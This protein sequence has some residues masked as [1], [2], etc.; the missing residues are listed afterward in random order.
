MQGISRAIHNPPTGQLAGRGLDG[1]SLRCQFIS[2]ENV[3]QY[4]RQAANAQFCHSA[5]SPR[6]AVS[7]NHSC[8]PRKR[9]WS[10]DTTCGNWTK[11]GE[12]SAQVGHIDR[13]GIRTGALSEDP[14]ARSWNSSHPSRGCSMDALR[15]TGGGG[16]FYCFAAK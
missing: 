9:R 12:G 15:G 13:K 2:R 10:G 16:L 11:S 3:N 14:P 7:G 1:A 6:S 8:T 5:L 4:L